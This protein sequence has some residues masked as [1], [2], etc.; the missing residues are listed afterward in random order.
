MTAYSTQVVIVFYITAATP[1]KVHFV[2]LPFTS[3]SLRSNF[4]FSHFKNPGYS[5]GR[6]ISN[7]YSTDLEKAEEKATTK[8]IRV[9]G[10]PAPRTMQLLNA[11]SLQVKVAFRGNL[12]SVLQLLQKNGVWGVGNLP[13]KQFTI[14]NN[15][16]KYPSQKKLALLF[17]LG[18]GG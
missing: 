4:H 18:G 11:V 5:R 12:Q 16:F 2:N 6:F 14:S 1:Q 10:I 13:W 17:F 15:N 7:I 3:N 9:W 8:V